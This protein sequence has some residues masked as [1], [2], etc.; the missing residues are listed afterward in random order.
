MKKKPSLGATVDNLLAVCDVKDIIVAGHGPPGAPEVRRFH[1]KYPDARIH[2]FEPQREFYNECM[3]QYAGTPMVYMYPYALGS[4]IGKSTLRVAN[5]GGWSSL[6]E[7]NQNWLYGNRPKHVVDSYAVDVVSVD[8]FCDLHDIGRLAL[9]FLDVQGFEHFVV[10]GAGDM[11]DRG[12]IDVMVGE[13]IFN[14]LHN[15]GH[16]F[17]RVYQMLSIERDY[18]FVG[19]YRPSQRV[20]GRVMFCDYIF[21][22][23]DIVEEVIRAHG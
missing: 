14:N 10:K 4:D 13:A 23:R 6:L 12:D 1:R 21:A 3:E 11:F 20:W 8:W 15:D 5:V 9:L 18:V 22:R 17:H 19:W 7:F 2:S 16:S